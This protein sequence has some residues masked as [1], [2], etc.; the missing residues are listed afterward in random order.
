MK[1]RQMR[2]LSILFALLIVGCNQDSNHRSELKL[3]AS[4]VIGDVG[5]R[6]ARVWCQ[7]ASGN[8]LE[9]PYVYLLDSADQ[10]MVATPMESAQ[11]GGCFQLQLSDLSPGTRYRYF[12]GDEHGTPL[13]EMLTIRTQPLWQYRTDPP[14]LNFLLGS[15]T[16][17]NEPEYDRPGEP[18]G[19]GYG[20]FNTMALEEFDA[21]LWLGDN[22]YLRE[23]DVGSLSGFVHRY[24]HTRSLPEM[25]A[26]LSK[27]S[28]YAIWDD[29]DFG[30]NDCDGSWIHP[31]WS[32]AAF[33][34]FWP[35][36]DSGIPAATEL[37]TT[38]FLYGDVEFF[39]LD[40]RSRRVNHDMGPQKRQVLGEAQRNWLLNA[41]RNSRAPFKLVAIG[42][43]MVS[44]AAIY[45]NFAQFPEERALLFNAID[46][47]DIRG[48]VFLSGDRHNS[49]LSKM[50]LPGG[51]WVYDLTVSPL[52]SGSYD[53]EDEPNTNREPGTMVGLRNYGVLN[54][55]GPRKERVL[56]MTVKDAEG[57]A[58]WTRSI[59]AGHGHVLQ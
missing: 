45:E 6:S 39:L 36:P 46:E 49:E 10:R 5:M 14:E 24:T 22:V 21:M 59:D 25:Q 28:H 35:N 37:N 19:G 30:P 11:L 26:L 9:K 27:G 58:L 8:Q 48:V 16:Y 44:D 7:L 38:H 15:C 40:N 42:G 57:R 33:E 47:L 50:E 1:I 34:A 20:I 4:P 43:Q 23:A 18:Y 52:T 12:I 51:N 17:I 55:A 3:N 2:Y 29:H 41:L 32:R 56:T 54:V 53:H 31:D 13:S